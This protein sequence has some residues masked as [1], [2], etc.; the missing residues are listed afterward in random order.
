MQKRFYLFFFEYLIN[1]KRITT[2]KCSVK[3]T[4]KRRKE[5]MKIN[6]MERK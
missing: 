6:T 5:G 1:S 3:K 4:K 2:E